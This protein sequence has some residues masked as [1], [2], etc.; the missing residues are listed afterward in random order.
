MVGNHQMD[1]PDPA[2]LNGHLITS[3]RRRRHNFTIG[4]Y[5]RTLGPFHRKGDLFGVDA[6]RT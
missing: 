4:N 6:E 3:T 1:V 2:S 5:S